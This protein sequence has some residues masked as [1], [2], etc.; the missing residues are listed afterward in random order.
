MHTFMIRI[1][2]DFALIYVQYVC[3]C[4]KKLNT[5][6]DILYHTTTRA[7]NA[8]ENE[9]HLRSTTGCGNALAKP[10]ACHSRRENTALVNIHML[11]HTV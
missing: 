3:C 6:L 10:A 9:K 11:V 8:S 7:C 1:Y 4:L 5:C 2:Q